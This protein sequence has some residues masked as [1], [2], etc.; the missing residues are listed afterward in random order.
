VKLRTGRTES[1][2]WETAVLLSGKDPEDQV[3]EAILSEGR[4]ELLSMD[5]E[6]R[7]AVLHEIFSAWDHQHSDGFSGGTQ[8]GWWCYM[9]PRVA[10][11]GQ[12][13]TVDGHRVSGYTRTIRMPKT[14]TMSLRFCHRQVAW[15]QVYGIPE[16]AAREYHELRERGIRFHDL[17]A[18]A[19][20]AE[21]PQEAFN[22]GLQAVPESEVL[23]M[24]WLWDRHLELEASHEHPLEIKETEYQVGATIEVPGLNLHRRSGE[25]RDNQPVAIVFMGRA[26]A[27]GREADGTPVV[28]EHRTGAGATDVNQLELDIY[29]I[30][31]A[32]ITKQT[33][34]AVHLHA[35]GLSDGPR[36]VREIYDESRLREAAERLEGPAVAA[37]NFHPEDATDPS[38]N[39]GPWCDGC[40]F[41]LRCEEHR[42]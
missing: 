41:R 12:Y 14:A 36:C 19:L 42:T 38:F 30:G 23:N 15:K 35:L 28:V 16:D 17:I 37:A 1:S 3:I 4:L 13:P 22:L 34:V 6:S 2:A 8:P 24:R 40:V 26:D 31:A 11:C 20:K 7:T 25:V 9:C 18:T 32:L 10:R 27:T 39:V 29:A 33:Q 5:D 21:N